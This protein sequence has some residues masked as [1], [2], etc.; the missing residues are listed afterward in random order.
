MLDPQNG[1]FRI[2]DKLIVGIGSSF[3]DIYKLAP[4]GKL[5]DHQNG[6]KW[7]YLNE[8]QMDQF[9]FDIGICYFNDRL[10][11]IDFCFSES[12]QQNISWD[13]WNE[14][15]MLKWKNI[16]ERWL[17]HSLGEK[18]SF[19]WGKIGAFY[20]PRSGTTSISIQYKKG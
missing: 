20:D 11:C 4:S 3:D 10:F 15:D 14:P 5:L 17:T 2:S 12:Q 6:Y 9:Y 7:I 1:Y 18:R 13:D 8:I 16:Y 19:H